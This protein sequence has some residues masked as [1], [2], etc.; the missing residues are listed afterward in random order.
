MDLLDRE[1]IYNLENFLDKDNVMVYDLLDGKMINSWYK[2][3]V[4]DW[5]DFKKL[6]DKKYW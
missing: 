4:K 2:Y 6:W 1:I 5:N 3:L